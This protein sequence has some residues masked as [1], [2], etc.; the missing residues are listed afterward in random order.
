MARFVGTVQDYHHFIGPRIR[1]VVNQAAAPAR[2][3]RGGI[4][5][6]CGEQHE[7]QSAHVHGRDRRTLI[8]GVLAPYT[9]PDGYVEIEID[10]VER[11]IIDAHMPIEETFKFICASCHRAYDAGTTQ[12]G[13]TRE[14][15]K[16][17][18]SG[19]GEFKKLGRIELWAGRPQQDNHQMIRAF[20]GLEQAG[21]VYLS[22]LREYCERELGMTG[23]DGKYASLKTDAGNSY[24]KVFFDDGDVVKMWPIVREEVDR[25]F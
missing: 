11:Q 25:Y 10:D 4:C 22:V 9:R 20:L 12:R 13:A 2:K 17:R 18:P 19:N 16:N 1:N 15:R 5:E 7:L 24:G 23:F 21:E 14:R 6:H 3:S 8:E